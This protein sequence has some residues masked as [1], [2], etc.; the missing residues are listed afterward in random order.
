MYLH[1]DHTEL[2]SIRSIKAL[3]KNKKI[4]A[5]IIYQATKKIVISLYDSK[6]IELLK[7]EN[8]KNKVFNKTSLIT[9]FHYNNGSLIE[10]ED[11]HNIKGVRTELFIFFDFTKK[12]ENISYD[13]FER[14]NYKKD[15]PYVSRSLRPFMATN[16]TMQDNLKEINKLKKYI[17]RDFKDFYKSEYFEFDNNKLVLA[18]NNARYDYDKL[19]RNKK[20]KYLIHFS[21]TSKP[22][23]DTLEYLTNKFD[24]NNSNNLWIIIMRRCWDE[25][26]QYDTGLEKNKYFNMIEKYFGKHEDYNK[27]FNDLKKEEIKQKVELF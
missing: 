26:V 5:E 11:A 18:I 6:N 25:R 21:L 13:F 22:I 20:L 16:K 12:Q 15:I 27:Y 4:D 24:L 8:I 1:K 17:E 14:L 3:I 23:Y 7:I 10:I 2:T 19:Q 9:D